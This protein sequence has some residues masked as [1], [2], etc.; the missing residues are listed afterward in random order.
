M[1]WNIENKIMIVMKYLEWNDI[2]K[3]ENIHIKTS[4]AASNFICT[5]IYLIFDSNGQNI[6]RGE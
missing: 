4:I 6:H 5:S 3:D 2:W 1:Q